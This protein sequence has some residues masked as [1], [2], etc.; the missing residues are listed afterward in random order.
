MKT[1]N[2][3]MHSDAQ[4]QAVFTH[5]KSSSALGAGDAYVLPPAII[6]HYLEPIFVALTRNI[7]KRLSQTEQ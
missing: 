3:R 5:S 7:L 2:N 4:S 6:M 1:H